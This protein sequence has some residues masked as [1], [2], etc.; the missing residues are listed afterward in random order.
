[1]SSCLYREGLRVKWDDFNVWGYFSTLGPS[2]LPSSRIVVFIELC[3]QTFH[4]FNCKYVHISHTA[5]FFSSLFPWN[6]VIVVHFVVVACH[7]S[8]PF[9]VEIPFPFCSVL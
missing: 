1:M 7:F 2:L 9:V 3:S 6:G 5:S 4:F 8:R